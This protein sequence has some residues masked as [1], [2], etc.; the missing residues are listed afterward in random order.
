MADKRIVAARL[1]RA[2]E[3]LLSTRLAICAKMG[4]EPPPVLRGS[5]DP[6]FDRMREVEVAANFFEELATKLGVEVV[7][8]EDP[9]EEAPENETTENVA[10]MI[11]VDHMPGDPEFVPSAG[12]ETK[13]DAESVPA[14]A[15]PQRGRQAKPKT[16]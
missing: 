6:V 12:S 5:Q 14:Q 13:A 16:E 9:Q 8:N 11:P 3:K 7:V 15:K 4:L 10:E 2:T 1:Q